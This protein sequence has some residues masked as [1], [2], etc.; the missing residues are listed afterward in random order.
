MRHR[1]LAK[2]RSHKP[3]RHGTKSRLGNGPRPGSISKRCIRSVASLWSAPPSR[4]SQG[5]HARRPRGRPKRP[6]K[7]GERKF[8]ALR[9]FQ[10]GRVIDRQAEPLGQTQCR[11]PCVGVRLRINGDRQRAEFRQGIVAERGVDP[12]APDRHLKAVG[13]FQP[14]QG[15]NEGA[16]PDDA[17]EERIG[18]RRASS[19]KYQISVKDGPRTRLTGDRRRSNP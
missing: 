18:V 14:P 11:G 15:R 7:C 19:S 12:F 10:I 5:F 13:D 1:R 8:P 6:V 9:E 3:T 2:A 16:F 4:P 17:V